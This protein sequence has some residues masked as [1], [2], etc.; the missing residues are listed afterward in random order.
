MFNFEKK[1]C[2]GALL[3]ACAHTSTRAHT[4]THAHTLSVFCCLQNRSGWLAEVQTT[5]GQ[6]LKAEQMNA[7]L[8][9]AVTAAHT[10]EVTFFPCTALLSALHAS[11]QAPSSLFRGTWKG[12][13]HG[14]RQK[15]ILR[16]DH[17]LSFYGW[18]THLFSYCPDLSGVRMGNTSV[19]EQCWALGEHVQVRAD[20][21]WV[22]LDVAWNRNGST[23][24]PFGLK[25]QLSRSSGH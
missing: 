13:F 17:V 14:T 18:C 23:E 1:F 11:K 2:L 10:W 9:G 8:R 16:Q 24:E 7:T 20:E 21:P 22:E 3:H 15:R 5:I 4:Q 6:A 19:N 12:F 25:P